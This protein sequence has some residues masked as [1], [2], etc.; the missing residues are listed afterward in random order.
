MKQEL[1]RVD[2][3][4]PADFVDGS[5]LNGVMQRLNRREYV[6]FLQREIERLKG[7]RLCPAF[8]VRMGCAS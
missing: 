3:L 1:E 7:E 2:A 5:M 6:A 4:P 8:A